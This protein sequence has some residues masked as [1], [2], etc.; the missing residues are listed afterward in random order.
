MKVVLLADVKGLGKIDDIVNVSPG[1]ANNFLF[2][3]QLAL[4]ATP[5]NLHDVK[6]RKKSEDEKAQQAYEDA[7]VLAEELEGKSFDLA[8]KC[9]EGGRLYGSVTGA[10]I[11]DVISKAGYR[12]DKRN[13][14]VESHIK[15][16]GTFDAKIKLHSKVSVGI[17][18]NIV[19]INA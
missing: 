1:Y 14:T 4:E 8:M 7:K 13:I 18:L 6:M 12:V 15:N 9:G 10:D 3:K 11:A 19:D 17:K 16:L 5:Q 2:K